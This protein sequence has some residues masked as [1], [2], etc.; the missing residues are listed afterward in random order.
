MKNRMNKTA[1]FGLLGLGI[2]GV[3]LGAVTVAKG[4]REAPGSA[5]LT[6]RSRRGEWARQRVRSG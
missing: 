1:A 5:E 4:L 6:P 2:A 3:V